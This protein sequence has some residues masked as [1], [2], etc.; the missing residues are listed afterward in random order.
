MARH[1][2]TWLGALLAAPFLLYLAWQIARI[3]TV[4]EQLAPAA[5]TDYRLYIAATSRWLTGG[6]FYEPFQLAGPYVVTPPAVLYPPTT[7]LLFAPFTVLPA[8]LWWAIPLAVTTWIVAWH[9]PRPI[10]WPVLALCIA[11]PTSIEVVYAGNPVLWVIC[12]LALGTRF[13]WPAVGVLLKPTLAPF[14]L[15]GINRR[16]WWL[17]LTLGVAVSLVFLPMWLDYVS[18]LRNARDPSGLAYSL[19]QVPTTFI[20]IVA[21]LGSQRRTL[22][23]IAWACRPLR[24][25]AL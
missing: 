17:A 13:G 19:N 4:W 3:A 14:A 25:P 6:S 24:Q 10:V 2:P 16:T 23:R 8:I 9:R 1:A 18:A 22:P 15:V 5:G 20:P 11:F 12:L 21:W 7:M